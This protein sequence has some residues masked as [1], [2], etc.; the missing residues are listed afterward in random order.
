MNRSKDENRITSPRELMKAAMRREPTE[1]IPTM[2]QICH[3]TPVRI[4]AAAD[5]RDWIDGLKRCLE[6]PA[7]IYDYVIRLVRDV[8]ADGLRLFV[9]PESY[10]IRR[11]GDELIT[12]DPETGKRTGQV[13]RHGGGGVMADTPPSPVETPAEAKARL[14]AMV[15]AF[16]AQKMA[17]LKE[18]RERVPDLF[19][20]SSSGG[21]TMS[22]YSL[23][24]GRVQAMTDLYDRPDFV[25]TVMD[26][27]VEAAV[28]RFEKLLA[29]GIDGFYIGDPSSSASLISPDHFEQFCLP[30]Y[31]KFC[32][33]FKKNA[34]E[35]VIYIH[36]CGRSGPILEMMAETGADVVEP[37]DPLGGVSV[38]DAKRRIGGKVALMG[39]VNTLT[40]SSGTAEE[41]RS[42]AI[43]KCLEGGPHGYVLGAGDMVPP[44]TPYENLKAMVEVATKS[45]W[46]V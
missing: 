19:V 44:G 42:E 11:I 4:Y 34:P 21:F 15:Q 39:G 38:L 30:A 1:R 33:H 10:T 18:A 14:D 7:L 9:K 23:L 35:I 43:R 5:G 36:I 16:T 40:L 46:K 26:M 32:G 12:V 31:Q 37:L 8:G 28:A 17:V 3:D 41:V 13:D 22:A 29:T 45:L 2:P 27:Q 24:R 6:E 20:A 25:R